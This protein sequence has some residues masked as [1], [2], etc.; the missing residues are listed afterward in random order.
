MATLWPLSAAASVLSIVGYAPE[1]R[2]LW[3]ERR[4]TGSGASLWVLWAM[5]SGLAL[6][7]AAAARASSLVVANFAVSF[8][9]CGAVA[10]ANVVLPPAQ[11]SK[12]K[13]K[14]TV[15]PTTT[16]GKQEEPC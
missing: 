9:V 5:S 10:V 1:F 15:E 14:P 7:N 13:W 3:Q 4:R 8:V 2:R 6:A 16:P 11:P 12:A